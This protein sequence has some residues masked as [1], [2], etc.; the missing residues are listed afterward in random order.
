M[1]TCRSAN[2]A[3]PKKAIEAII[4][5]KVNYPPFL[6][7]T[8]K[9][10]SDTKEG[11]DIELECVIKANPWI[12]NITWIFEDHPLAINNNLSILIMNQTLFL[13]NVKKEHSG[14]YRCT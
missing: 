10:H 8:K 3:L 14:R 5:I 7:L 12:H 1:L 9:A 6:I 11:D 4:N 13:Q 2:A